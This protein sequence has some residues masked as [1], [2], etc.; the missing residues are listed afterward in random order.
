MNNGITDPEALRQA[1]VERLTR[2]VDPETG[3]DI[4]RMRLIE[5]LHVDEDGHV[6]YIFRP[7]SPLC[8][9]AVPL[10]NEIQQA[11]AEVPGVNSQDLKIE[12][13]ALSED[14]VALLKQALEDQF[15]KKG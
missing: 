13:Y 14:L 7:S 5:N 6:A 2:V 10:A 3:V 9:I 11:V 4:I 15:G 12:G 1:V 8:P